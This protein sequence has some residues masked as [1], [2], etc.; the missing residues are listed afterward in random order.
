MSLNFLFV[1]TGPFLYGTAL[2][3]KNN[4]RTAD[5]Q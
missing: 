1:K 4:N 3:A 2:F 5:L